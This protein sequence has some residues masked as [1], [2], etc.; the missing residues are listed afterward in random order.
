MR[1]RTTKK[2]SEIPIESFRRKIPTD[3]SDVLTSYK[4]VGDYRSTSKY[5]LFW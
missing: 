5:I 1:E 2:K 3:L 4:F